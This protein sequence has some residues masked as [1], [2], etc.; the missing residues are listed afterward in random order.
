MAKSTKAQTAYIKTLV[1][2]LKYAIHTINAP[3]L[4]YSWINV[5]EDEFVYIV[6]LNDK[7]KQQLIFKIPYL[8]AQMVDTVISDITVVD[9]MIEAYNN[10]EDIFG[11]DCIIEI[12]KLLNGK[13]LALYHEL[14][15]NPKAEDKHKKYLPYKKCF[16]KKPLVVGDRVKIGHPLFTNSL[17]E[18]RNGQVPLKHFILPAMDEVIGMTATV[19]EVDSKA[20]YKCCNCSA[21]HRATIK[22]GFEDISM[23]FYIDKYFVTPENNE[24][25]QKTTD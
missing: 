25:P 22:I 20:T 21:E 24:R 11:E 16:N 14:E 9:R 2:A 13:F 12:D 6:K 17:V 1:L 7:A 10:H 15:D 5:F 8:L 18:V 19:L 3:G 4:G 23:E